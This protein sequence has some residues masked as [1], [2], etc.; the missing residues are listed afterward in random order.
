MLLQPRITLRS[1]LATATCSLLSIDCAYAA[2]APSDLFSA[3]N[4]WNV[5][6]A[7]LYYSEKDRV[8]VVEPVVQ[9]KTEI[10]DGEFI[11]LKFAYDAIS[12]ATPNG[13]AP[14][15]VPHA[16]GSRTQTSSA[17]SGCSSTSTTVPLVTPA[18]ELPL[19]KFS[20]QRYAI[21]VDWDQPLTRTLR[22]VFGASLSQE[23]DYAALGASTSLLWDIN[24]KLTTLTAVA[25]ID[26]DQVSPIGGTHAA[27]A[28]SSDSQITSGSNKK[29]SHDM[30]L[31]ITQVITRRTLMQFNYARGVSTGYLTD[32]YKLVSVVDSGGNTADYLHEKRPDTRTR[33]ALYLKTVYHL[34][35]DV[36][37]FSYRQYWDDWG[38]T[39]HTADLTYRFVLTHD[40]YLEPHLRYYTQTAADFFVHS[41]LNSDPLPGYTSADLRLGAFK[42]LTTGLRY[43]VEFYQGAEYGIGMDYMTQTGDGHPASAIGL[44]K[45]ENL[46]PELKA[47]SVFADFS[48]KF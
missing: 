37:H 33:N 21:S 8:T 11:T 20:D 40:T 42:S 9:V 17:C 48:L 41:L 18:H 22:G 34:T 28:P 25:S 44:Q 29:N 39:S 36:V 32:P 3:E 31:G 1:A 35:E 4:P 15:N 2:I 13:A 24:N 10:D 5:N 14:T 27:F 47:F 45:N 16:F 30:L 26:A 19:V 7:I 46:F 38:I 23:H 12:G 6:S 43:G